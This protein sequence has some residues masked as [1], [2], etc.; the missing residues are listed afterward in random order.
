MWKT[1]EGLSK[2]FNKV[3]WAAEDA[4][5]RLKPERKPQ[6]RAAGM[7]QCAVREVWG[8]K[9]AAESQSV[10]FTNTMSSFTL[11]SL[12]A[13]RASGA[14]SSSKPKVLN[15]GGRVVQA[16]TNVRNLQQ[17]EMETRTRKGVGGLLKKALDEACTSR[18][19]LSSFVFFFYIYHM[20]V[21]FYNRI[22][23][24]QT[25]E[26]ECMNVM[27]TERKVLKEHLVPFCFVL[28]QR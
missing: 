19:C 11:G 14:T 2:H 22:L 28:I 3:S 16:C 24:E 6:R 17:S 26:A 4:S 21:F 8:S 1:E 23:C 7:K 13:A 10:C 18:L 12:W 5:E 9:P 27:G 20:Y 25:E 15:S